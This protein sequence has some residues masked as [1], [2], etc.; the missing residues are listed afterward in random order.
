M[1]HYSAMS[2]QFSR[3]CPF[4]CEFC[5]I[6]EIYG[7]RPRTKTPQQI[8][9]ELDDLYRRNWRGSVFLVD[10]NFIGNKKKVKEL[11]PV[12]AEWNRDSRP[13]VQLL[14]GS[15]AEPG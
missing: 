5:D 7:R 9:A 6:I 11:L 13:A 1:K 8:V 4:N 2:V 3:G 12:L 15:L 14:H 10:D